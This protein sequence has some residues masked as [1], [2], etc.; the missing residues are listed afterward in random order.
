MK[1]NA[2]NFSKVLKEKRTQYGVS[3]RR[4]SVL[5]GYSREHINRIENEK[6]TP[7]E[8]MKA[9]LLTCLERVNPEN[10]FELVFDSVRLRFESH[11]VPYICEKILQIKMKYMIY[12][13]Y[14][15]YGYIAKY[16]FSDIQIMISP[17]EDEKGTLVELKGQGCREFENLL[18][19]QNRS[20]F[21]FFNT[22]E[23]EKVYY[24]RIDL[25]INDR[26][27]I[28]SIPYLAEKCSKKE[29]RSKFRSFRSIDSGKLEDEEEAANSL[30]TTLYLGSLKSDIY[31]CFYQKNYEQLVKNRISLED[32]PIMNRYEI[33]LK[34]DRAYYAIQD[35]LTHQDFE[36]TIFNIIN[37]YIVFL[38]PI[39]N[40]N[41]RKWATDPSWKLFLG[42]TRDKLKL[43]S[44]PQPYDLRRTLAWL[45]KQVAPTLKLLLLIDQEN[46]T[47]KIMEMISSAEFSSQQRKILEQFIPSD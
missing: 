1:E 29:L 26:V 20:W 43:T 23:K 24:K 12:E 44:E 8:K 3:Q 22:C 30:G 27:G 15:F 28:L 36:Q 37:T 46:S 18:V 4:L 5:S 25:E 2:M 19:A 17:E 35:I 7:S 47:N 11:D 32:S 40:Q 16:A 38:T 45:R 42:K 34:D 31:F 41:K 13:D 21:D 9:T 14:A 6:E 10:D 39:K 33:R